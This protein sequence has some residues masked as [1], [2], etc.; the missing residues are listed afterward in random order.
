MA[1]LSKLYGSILGMVFLVRMVSVFP[2]GF[3]V[4]EVCI[5][6]FTC[7]EGATELVSGFL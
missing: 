5:F 3:D 6:F 2:T 4:D 1:A 7:C